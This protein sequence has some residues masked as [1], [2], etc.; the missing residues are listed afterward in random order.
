MQIHADMHSWMEC[1]SA[2][3]QFISASILEQNTGRYMQIHADMHS[4]ESAYLHVSGCILLS[5]AKDTFRYA[6]DTS[7]GMF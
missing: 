7:L 1:I 2:C 3:I 5:C 6:Q 4:F